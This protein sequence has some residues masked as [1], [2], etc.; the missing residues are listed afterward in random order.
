MTRRK[1]ARSHE[2]KP[3]NSLAINAA[4]RYQAC[5]ALARMQRFTLQQHKV[6]PMSHAARPRT[7]FV[8]TA[9]PYA[10]GPFHIGHIMEYI[11][12]DIW[13]RFQRM[14]GTPGALRLRRRRARRADHAQGRSRRHHARASSIARGRQVASSRLAA[15]SPSAS[16]TDAFDATRRRTSSSSQAIYRRLRDRGL[17]DRREADRAVL[18]SGQGHVPAGPLHQGHVPEVRHEG[19]V[20]AT[21]A[22]TAARRTRRPTSSN[23]YSALTGAKPELRTSEHLFFRLVR[24]GGRRISCASGRKPKRRCSPKCSTRCQEW[25]GGDGERASSPTGTSRATRRYFGIE[26]P[27]MPSRGQ[28]LLR[29]ARRADRLSRQR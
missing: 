7:L 24:A 14:Q 9:L 10:N 4:A 1:S 29:L 15:L 20:R 26:I 5:F 12:A 22:R 16:T 8:T 6:Y 3:R 18:R 23:P 2:A 25:L 11:Q 13:V 19:P 21:P 17:A 27:P 28:V